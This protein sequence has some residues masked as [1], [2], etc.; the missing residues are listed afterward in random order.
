MTMMVTMMKE[1]MTWSRRGG[2]AIIFHGSRAYLP[3]LYMKRI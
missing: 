2:K 3:E 1:G